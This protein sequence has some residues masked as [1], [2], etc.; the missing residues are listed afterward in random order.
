ME[1]KMISLPIKPENTEVVFLDDGS[2]ET[3]TDSKYRMMKCNAILRHKENQGRPF[4]FFFTAQNLYCGGC[5]ISISAK[6]HDSAKEERPHFMSISKFLD[7]LLDTTI[8]FSSD[9]SFKLKDYLDARVPL[10][11]SADTIYNHHLDSDQCYW[12]LR[13]YVQDEEFD[14]HC[15]LMFQTGLEDYKEKGTKLTILVDVLHKNNAYRPTV[16]RAVK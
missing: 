16:K 11:Q 4:S 6:L 5:F 8:R 3:S 9:K 7:Y 1:I 12:N 15:A 10:P 2:L 13:E 14:P